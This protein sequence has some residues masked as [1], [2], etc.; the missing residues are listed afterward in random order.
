MFYV[1][2]IYVKCFNNKCQ[3]GFGENTS[4][5]LRFIF[6]VLSIFLFSFVSSAYIFSK[7]NHSLYKTEL[8]TRYGITLLLY[9]RSNPFLSMKIKNLQWN[10]APVF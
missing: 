6:I 8:N 2:C 4:F 7:K 1:K 3:Q 5:H 10:F 9:Q